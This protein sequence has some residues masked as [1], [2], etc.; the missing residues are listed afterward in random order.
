[1]SERVK[2][3][4]REFRFKTAFCCI[5]DGDGFEFP[6]AV[7][8]T[9]RVGKGSGVHD[10][11]WIESKDRGR[12]NTDVMIKRVGIGEIIRGSG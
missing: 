12:C 6:S 9:K 10:I 7:S 2:E 3:M 4:A 5:L 8:S 1:M 11:W